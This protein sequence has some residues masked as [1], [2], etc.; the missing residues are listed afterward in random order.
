MKR[1]KKK[2]TDTQK[3][4]TLFFTLL[5]V[6][7]IG[8]GIVYAV[9]TGV[10]KTKTKERMENVLAYMKNQCIRYDDIGAEE[11]T[12]SLVRLIDKTEEFRRDFN[13]SRE[14]IDHDFL[15]EYLDNQRLSGI[16]ITDSN[17]GESF[18]YNTDG[19]TKEDWESVLKKV[20]EVEN[21]PI[22]VYTERIVMN[23]GYYY[24][25]AVGAREDKQGSILC[26]LRQE[27]STTAGTRLSVRTLLDGYDFDMDGIVVITD[28]I[29]VIG[30]NDEKLSGVLVEKNELLLGIREGKGGTLVRTRDDG[31]VYYGMREKC[32]DYGIYVI[33]PAKR[34]FTERSLLAAYFTV[35]YV[36]LMAIIM[37]SWQIIAGNRRKEKER[38][39]AK[40]RE[41][42]D[43][44][45]QDAIRANEAKT[46][47]LRRMSHDI[48]TPINGILGML[49]IA[50]YY[51][52]DPE[53]QEECRRKVR[54]ASGYLMDLLSD[55]LD[56]SKL[57]QGEVV[58]R[59]EPFRM[60]ALLSEVSAIMKPMATE[61]GLTFRE[62]CEKLPHNELFGSPM[63]LKRVC[64]N[65]IGNAVKYTPTGGVI[66][67]SFRELSCDGE[68]AEYELVCADN[69]I[70]MSR[71]FQERMY[72]PFSQED[73]SFKAS[74]SGTGL[75]LSIVKNLV[76]RMD[77]TISVE[78]ESGAGT[79][80]TVKVWFRLDR[81]EQSEVH[82][83][84]ETGTLN[85]VRVLL[86]ED[87]ELNMEIS[88]FV[89]ETAKASVIPV[90]NG[91][92]AVERFLASRPGELDLI[93]M[94]V[95]MPVMDG[96]EATKKIRNS[97]RKD[98]DIPIIAMT[99]NAY[100]DDV[101]RVKAA[102]MD[103]HFAKPLDSQRLIAVILEILKKRREKK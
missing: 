80:F 37:S 55:I 95:M 72:E 12:K 81:K 74:Y 77:G 22:K 30:S 83:A 46:D 15:Q 56:M 25:Y 10:G 97:G 67:V 2:L 84:E 66:T 9:G 23:Q 89:L 50:E 71:E 94:D 27:V 92:E 101:K 54:E 11:Q 33:S 64:M 60:D 31:T 53:K 103:E 34:V 29:S 42:L 85:G 16:I 65:L 48:R 19:S 76:E 62:S 6:G 70:G 47:F 57:E 32:K 44:L 96:I 91:Q 24:D 1:E 43:R 93:L 38:S 49:D 61:A 99:A 20:K 18:L 4:W 5:A 51:R 45:A 21:S 82:G 69:G 88:R 3:F 100:S 68:R 78:S 63:M 8:V 14:A 58:W 28:G 7:I 41:E 36:G 13:V 35:L 90:R 40:Y 79:T 73:P 26:Y 52:D 39:Q 98:A 102:G 59:E 17:A 87:N 86:A 75:G